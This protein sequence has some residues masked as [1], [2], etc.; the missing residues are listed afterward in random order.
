MEWK[1]QKTMLGIGNNQGTGYRVQGTGKRK[2]FPVPCSLSPERGFTLVEVMLAVTILAFGIVG[3]LRGYTTSVGALEAS[4][5]AI[6]AVCSLKEKMADF[7]KE[8]IE[9]GGLL[10]GADSGELD[11]AYGSGW[12]W[13]SEVSALDFDIEELKD[14]LNQ[15]KITVVNEQFKPVRRFSLVTYEENRE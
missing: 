3:V 11:T 9:E 7:E 8:A 14:I 2:L 15:V 12:R 10:V 6:E 13:E 5:K 4:Q 1:A